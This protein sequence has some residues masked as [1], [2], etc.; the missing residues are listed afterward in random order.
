[1]RNRIIRT[2]HSGICVM[3]QEGHQ[4]VRSTDNDIREFQ[5][6]DRLLQYHGRLSYFHL[7]QCINYLLLQ[8]YCLENASDY[9]KCLFI[10]RRRTCLQLFQVVQL[11]VSFNR[12]FFIRCIL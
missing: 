1:M 7:T 6:L 5:D 3:G 8:K 12:Q 4:A 9:L 11:N 10:L 2:D